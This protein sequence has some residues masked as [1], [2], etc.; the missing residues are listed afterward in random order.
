MSANS[1]PL[2][3]AFDS[4]LTCVPPFV[5]RRTGLC[6]TVFEQRR[7]RKPLCRARGTRGSNPPRIGDARFAVYATPAVK[8]DIAVNPHS[9]L[10]KEAVMV[11]VAHHSIIGN[12]HG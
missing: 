12:I 8:R 7:T 11:V 10:T 2:S 5:K 4:A 1:V 6:W 3:A 9:R